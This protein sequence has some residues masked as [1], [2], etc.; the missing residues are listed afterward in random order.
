M[1]QPLCLNCEMSLSDSVNFCPNCGQKTNT[2]RLSLHDLTHDTVHYF[3]HADKSIFKLLKELAVKPGIVAREYIT[4]KRQKYFKPLNFFLIVA[5]IVV[6]MTS[7]FYK[8]NDERSRR[9]EQSAQYIQDPVKKQ[10]VLNI[11]ARVSKVNLITGKYSNVIN[12]VA[13]PFLT[14]LFWFAYRRQFNFIESLVGNMYFIS[15]TMVFYALL[16][17]PL[18]YLIPAA[19]MYFLSIFFL[20]EVLYRGY[21]YYQFSNRKGR[22]QM[23]KAYG[24]SLL[25]TV[26]WI[27]LVYFAIRMYIQGG[28][29]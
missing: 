5:G 8:P 25:M 28:R 9:L 17:V 27:V 2:H 26:A 18:Q 12:M 3:T 20:F 14:L 1:H 22:L 16:I 24:V 4:G 19:G 21:A 15:Y 11:A 7:A 29:F 10:R 13:T 23:A 6:F